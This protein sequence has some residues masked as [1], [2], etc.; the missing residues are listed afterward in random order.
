MQ[1]AD[2]NWKREKCKYQSYGKIEGQGSSYFPPLEVMFNTL[3]K[4]GFLIMYGS[5]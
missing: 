1:R 2:N 4:K 5:N 3:D